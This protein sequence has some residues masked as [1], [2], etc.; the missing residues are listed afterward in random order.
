MGYESKVIIMDRTGEKWALELMRIDVSNMGHSKYNGKSFPE[1]FDTPIDFDIFVK[2]GCDWDGE[3]SAEYFRKDY[4]GKH[5]C[6]TT[7]DKLIEWL[8]GAME[9][10]TEL[11]GYRRA[12]MLLNTLKALKES[13]S[14]FAELV[15]VR[16]GY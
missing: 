1:V 10:D 12:K 15:A 4:Y 16:F 9:A 2:C 11:A 3:R 13:E 8:T 6:H 5:C 14:D 7:I